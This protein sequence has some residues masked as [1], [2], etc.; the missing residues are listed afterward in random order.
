[1]RFARPG[2]G[3][4][5]QEGGEGEVVDVDPDGAAPVVL[6][7]AVVF[8]REAEAADAVGGPEFGRV[9]YEVE[10]RFEARAVGREEAGEEGE[11]GDVALVADVDAFLVV[12]DGG[13]AVCFGF[14]GPVQV[15]DVFHDGGFVG[16]ELRGVGGL[17][18]GFGDAAHGA[19]H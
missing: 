19:G 10:D 17:V 15:V 9:G 13:V 5:V 14:G 6:V 3:G 7:R 16:A 8:V 11:D 1:L 4:D 2:L 18:D 12:I